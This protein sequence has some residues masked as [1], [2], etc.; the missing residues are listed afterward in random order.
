MTTVA[1]YESHPAVLAGL[2]RRLEA[3][4]DLDVVGA[5][6]D[7]F[8]FET[9]VA[10][11]RPDIVVVS[12]FGG[13]AIQAANLA[14]RVDR[15][16]KMLA[17]VPGTRRNERLGFPPTVEFVADG[18]RGDLLVKRVLRLGRSDSGVRRSCRPV[19]YG[20]IEAPAR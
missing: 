20:P 14:A 10:T 9:A 5:Y 13:G 11:H 18:P 8:R 16:M 6:G 17:L 19:T 7:L 2:R 1:I 15:G 4:A 3:E 12:G